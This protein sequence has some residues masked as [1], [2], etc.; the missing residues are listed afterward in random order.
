MTFGRLGTLV[1]CCAGSNPRVNLLVSAHSPKA[2][3]GNFV[4]LGGDRPDGSLE[5]DKDRLTVIQADDAVRGPGGVHQRGAP[6]P[7][8]AADDRRL[9]Q[10]S[11]RLLHADHRPGAQ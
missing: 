9:G 6:A 4:V 2:R 10:A 3:Q 5:Q 8:A 11:D 1:A 7:Q